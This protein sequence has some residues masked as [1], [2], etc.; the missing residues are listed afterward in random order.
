MAAESVFDSHYDTEGICADS[1][2]NSRPSA[3]R[4]LW[5]EAMTKTHPHVYKMLQLAA[6]GRH[7]YPHAP[8]S[9]HTCFAENVSKS[10]QTQTLP[11]HPRLT[12]RRAVR[13]FG[14]KNY[15]SLRDLMMDVGKN[16]SKCIP[17]VNSDATIK[18]CP[19]SKGK[20]ATLSYLELVRTGHWFW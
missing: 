4:Q 11:S 20:W 16:G 2:G 6:V 18:T 17:M 19:H 13:C 9:A 14:P 8:T 3:T 15:R 10:C 12:P 7:E 5:V 1:R